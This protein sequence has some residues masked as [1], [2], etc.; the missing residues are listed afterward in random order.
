[1]LTYSD[2]DVK[3][4]YEKIYG[5]T[6]SFEPIGHHTIGRNLVYLINNETI[7]KIYFK[8]DKAI[9][10]LKSIPLIQEKNL[11]CP[12]VLDHGLMPNGED[13]IVFTKLDGLI[14]ETIES[15][16][17]DSE[18]E[19]IYYKMGKVL[20]TLHTIEVPQYYDSWVL[21]D[22]HQH[23]SSLINMVVYN[24]NRFFE[25]IKPEDH[26]EYDLIKE[27]YECIMTNLS[28]FEGEHE[29][30]LSHHDFSRRNV[31]IV[32]NDSYDYYGLIDFEHTKPSD[33]DLEMVDTYLPLLE[34]NKHLAKIFLE[35]YTSIRKFN[36]NRFEKK[37]HYYNIFIGIVTCSWAK[38]KAY[39]YYLTG[40]EKIKVSLK[41]IQ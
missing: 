25:R 33:L 27:G 31:L 19:I 12:K 15:E 29:I 11:V 28:L 35:G 32:K 26:D 18:L 30:V 40:L 8:P 22:Q 37:K 41:A 5:S 20:A 23:A 16:L 7:L 34:E 36:Y 10:E 24:T 3:R 2:Y 39:E 14:L 6:N 17:S 13:Y 21:D 38:E 9:N 4:F 1:M